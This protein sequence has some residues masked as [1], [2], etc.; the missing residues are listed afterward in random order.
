MRFVDASTFGLAFFALLGSTSVAT[1]ALSL[2]HKQRYSMGTMFD[3]V[4]YHSS[5]LEAERAIDRAMEEI[6][7]LD[8]VMS[9]FKPDS[10]L[11][12]LNREA[13]RRFVNV[14]PS[15]YE[16]IQES[17]RV[18]KRSAGKFDVTIAPL[19]RTWKEAQANGR[20]PSEG[21]LSDAKQCVGYERIELEGPNRIRFH[22]ECLEVDLGGIGKG[23]AVDRAIAVLRSAGIRHAI[24]NAGGSSISAIDA[25]PGEKGW[26]IRLGARPSA[27]ELLL[28]DSSISTS[29]QNGE[30]IDPQTLAPAL[31]RITVT[32]L[33]PS[34]TLADALS[35]TLLMMSADERETLLERF[36]GASALYLSNA[37]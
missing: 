36:A 18:S 13:R 32:V 4:A 5:R 7:R 11:S 23:Y 27:R 22:S 15:L 31:S 29:E 12:T 8:Q 24:V 17:I 25:P 19:L 20:K 35:T 37:H 21:E 1:Q 30:I 28:R 14:H 16:I 10:D 6:D 33:A 26:P 3:I 2:V 9:R 34:A